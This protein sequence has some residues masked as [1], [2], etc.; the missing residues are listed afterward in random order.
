[1]ENGSFWD[2]LE[3]FRRRLITVVIVVAVFSMI[4]FF[5]SRKLTGYVAGTSPV[6]L[7]ALTPAEAVTANI[8]ISVTAGIIASVP[9]ILF[10]IWRF[11]S[12]GLYR[13]ERKSVLGVTAAGIILFF[14]GAAFAWFVM[15]GPAIELFRSFETGNITGMWSV[16]SYLGFIGR[17]I[18]VFGSAFQLPL[19]VLFLAKTG[20]VEPSDIGAYRR[21]VLVGLLIIAAVLTPPDPLTQVML[22]LPLYVLFE[23]SLLAAGIAFRK[24]ETGSAL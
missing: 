16:S 5:F 20:I 4:A 23:I 6:P 7:A 22:T 9:V 11:V 21:H 8:R 17:F 1:M 10:Q 3:E 14:A 12:P 13:K 15:R 24:K 19:A 18:I 2:H